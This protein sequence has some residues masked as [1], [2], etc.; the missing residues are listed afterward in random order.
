MTE[1]Q[2]GNLPPHPPWPTSHVHSKPG[3]QKLPHGSE[4]KREPGI[5]LCIK[6]QDALA[7]PSLQ[8]I[9]DGPAPTPCISP[10]LVLCR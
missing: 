9:S 3:A 2:G 5:T 6:H 10:L 1:A 8:I 4:D 7:S